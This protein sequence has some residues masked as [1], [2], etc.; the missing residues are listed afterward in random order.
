MPPISSVL[1]NV[2]RGCPAGLPSP[3]HATSRAEEQRDQ[4]LQRTVRRDEHRAR[5]AKQHQ[6]EIFERAETQR[7]VGQRGCRK[8]QHDGAE[9]SADRGKDKAR[10]ECELCLTFLSHRKGFVGISGRRRCAGNAQQ[11]AGNV[12]G[13]N[14]HRS[15]C[16]DRGDRRNRRHEERHRYQ[17]RRRH[18]CGQPRHGTDEQ[19]EQRRQHHHQNGVRL[20]HHRESLREVFQHHRYQAKFV[21]T[22][23]GRGTRSNL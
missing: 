4:S 23:H 14:G 2:K 18:R 21:N 13:E 16:D 22:P 5:Q 20:E 8:D 10:A 9:E 6:P 15:G 19:T 3:T 17:Q 7:D 1:P 12:A 11:T